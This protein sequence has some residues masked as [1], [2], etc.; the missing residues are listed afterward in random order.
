MHFSSGRPTPFGHGPGFAPGNA[1]RRTLPVLRAIE[2]EDRPRG[3]PAIPTAMPILVASDSPDR[4]ALRADAPTLAIAPA[5]NGPGFSGFLGRRYPVMRRRRGASTHRVRGIATP[6]DS[7][8][9]RI[10]TAR[11]CR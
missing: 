2:R 1:G 6:S 5:R 11:T 7:S 10:Q 4:L 9:A 3:D 8:T